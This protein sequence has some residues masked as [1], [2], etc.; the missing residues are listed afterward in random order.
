MVLFLYL[1]YNFF[2]RCAKMVAM[3]RGLGARDQNCACEHS[4]SLGTY[5]DTSIFN[6][7]ST[8]LVSQGGLGGGRQVRRVQALRARALPVGRSRRWCNFR[9]TRGTCFYEPA[10]ILASVAL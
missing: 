6:L 9:R 5:N 7:R 4:N 8:R 2:Q 1:H 3:R 10:L